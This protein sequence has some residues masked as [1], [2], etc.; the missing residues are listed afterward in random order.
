SYFLLGGIIGLMGKVFQLSGT[1]LG[2]LIIV[3]GLV[4]LILGLQLTEIFPRISNGGLTLP[5]GIARLLGIKKHHEKEYS[6]INS[7]IVGALT[8]FLPCG[9]TQAMQLYAMSTGNFWSGALIMGVFALG[10]TPGLLGVGGLSSVLKGASAKK[11][12]KFAGLLVTILAI[13][14]I[15]NGINLTGW[16][17]NL[18]SNE[19]A[20]GE[21][22]QNDSNVTLENGVQVVKMVQLAGGYR[23]NKFTIKQDIPVK[24]LIDSQSDSCASS[25]TIPKL[26]IKKYLQR[27]ENTIEFTP[28][29]L[30]KLKFSCLMGMYTGEFNVIKNDL[31][32][33]TTTPDSSNSQPSPTTSNSSNDTASNSADIQEIKTTYISSKK[34]INPSEFN[35]KVNKPVRFEVAVKEDAY[36]CMSSI[37]IPGLTEEIYNL[38]TDEQIVFEFTPKNKGTYEITCGMGVPRGEIIVA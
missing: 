34:D 38:H 32:S 4:M 12:F 1:V 2:I 21:E 17:I 20:T 33:E 18:P 19:S 7:M 25:I 29:D 15:R 9:F 16:K 6:H 5:S 28:K 35:V 24:W 23:P 10:T 3:V 27:G 11:F 13:L 26:K 36:G 37:T 30:G 14:N 8:F 22:N 31:P